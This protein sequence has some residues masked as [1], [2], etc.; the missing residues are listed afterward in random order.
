MDKEVSQA[1]ATVLEYLVNSVGGIIED[2]GS[3]MTEYLKSLSSEIV[4]YKLG[5]A[6]LWVVVAIG[7]AVIGVIFLIILLVK[8]SDYA[9]W[10][11]GCLVGFGLCIGIYNAYTVIA[12]KTFPEKVVLDYIEKEY[13]DISRSSSR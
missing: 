12:C 2:K 11:C 4:A 7:L 6:W 1:F 5:I 8:D 10:V 13:S 9:L 3:D